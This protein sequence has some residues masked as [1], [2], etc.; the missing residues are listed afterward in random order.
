M[1]FSNR[2]NSEDE[3]GPQTS[4]KEATAVR[5]TSES[6][7]AV[8]MLKRWSDSVCFFFKKKPRILYL[9]KLTCEGRHAES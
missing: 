5:L 2:K 8:L 3:K 6:V 1:K 9:I 7:L 4:R